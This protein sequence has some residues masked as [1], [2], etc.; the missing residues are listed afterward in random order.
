M[1]LDKIN[2]DTKR[3]FERLIELTKTFPKEDENMWI[4]ADNRSD[5]KNYISFINKGNN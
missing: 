2:K 3:Y 1:D 5:F 4:V